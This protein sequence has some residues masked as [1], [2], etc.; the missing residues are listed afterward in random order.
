MT[1]THTSKPRTLVNI[2]GVPG[3]LLMIYL[4]GFWF[5]AFITVVILLGIIEL[6]SLTEHHGGDILYRLIMI[7]SSMYIALS[8]SHINFD[9]SLFIIGY[10]FLIFAIEA[11]RKSQKSLINISTSVFGFI[12][13][14]IF[15]SKLTLLRNIADIG[16]AL[17]LSL[18]LSVWLCD[19]MAYTFGSKF[20]KS[21]IL[22]SVSPNKTWVGTI[23]G[24]M[25][26]ILFMLLL[27][28]FNY[29]GDYLNVIDAIMLG[30]ITG[31]FG[32]LGDFAESLLKREAGIKDSSSILQGHG[33]I[34]D[35]FDS[36]MFA[37]QLTYFYVLY[38][39]L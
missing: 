16:F 35:R 32:Q 29:F 1:K 13:I 4:G 18:F 20:G 15:L 10:V 17:T 37:G 21:K 36:L 26:S 34:L 2:L 25:F 39:I 27:F 14:T 38:F 5:S 7:S 3:I 24:L 9:H 33:G 19:T 31:G 22:P 12:W 11:F 8:V 23:A 30:I 28:H 6:K